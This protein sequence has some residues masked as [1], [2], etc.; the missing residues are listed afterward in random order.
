MAVRTR[1]RA[2]IEGLVHEA[3][4][5]VTPVAGPY[6]HPFHPILVTVPIG[7]WIS[8]LI[9]DIASRVNSDGSQ[10]LV[11]ASYWLIGIG[12]IGALVA[13][14][15]GLLDLLA[16]PRRTRAM[17]VGLIHL[18]LN[19]I[20]VALFALGFWWR[21]ATYY[22]STK[23][24]AGPFVLSIVAIVLLAV[25]GWLGGQLAYRFGVR[26]ADETAQLDGYR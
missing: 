4:E 17:R 21:H 22:E 1:D 8:S 5:P 13:A 19:L 16:I 25:S 9:F 6:G 24:E 7:A 10:P 15:F 20:I 23:V 12:V 3:K 11:E 14:V 18:G 26:V 2:S